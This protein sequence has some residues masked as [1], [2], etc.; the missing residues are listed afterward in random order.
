[1]KPLNKI[2]PLLSWKLFPERLFRGKRLTNLKL[3]PYSAKSFLTSLSDL[4]FEITTWFMLYNNKKWLSLLKRIQLTSGVLLLIAIAV[5][6]ILEQWILVT[7][8]GSFLL[9]MS[10]LIRMLN[11]SFVRIQL[12]STKLIIRYYSLYAIDREYESIEFPIASLR[13][14]KIKKYLFGLKWDLHLT[15]KLR[16]GMASYPA[17]CLSAVPFADR[18]VLVDALKE[19]VVS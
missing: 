4:Y 17:I 12:D 2:I 5:A 9:L 8:L 13:Y 7:C 10:I 6:I 3:P 18:K 19:L 15:V 1:M 16:Q 14:V 11:F